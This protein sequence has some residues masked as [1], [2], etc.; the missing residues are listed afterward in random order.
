M[1]QKLNLCLPDR[2]S[3]LSDFAIKACFYLDLFRYDAEIIID[4][5]RSLDDECYG[6]CV[7]DR[8]NVQIELA[9]RS[10]G[11]LVDKET[12]LR[13]CAHELVHA[14]QYL[15]GKLRDVEKGNGYEVIWGKNK[16]KWR[17][18][19][20]LARQPWEAEAYCLENEIYEACR[21]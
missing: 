19:M 4:V 10:F 21:C 16:Y 6:S 11:E 3:Y 9:V 5:K 7:G 14:K 1:K 8:K 18:N 2:P 13:T 17:S 15:T 20:A 12:R